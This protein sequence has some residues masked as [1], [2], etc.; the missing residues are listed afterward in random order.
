MH[1]EDLR[2]KELNRDIPTHPPAVAPGDEDKIVNDG[3]AVRS[4]DYNDPP[5]PGGKGKSTG[6][7]VDPQVGG[8][9][10]QPPDASGDAAGRRDSQTRAD[11]L[12]EPRK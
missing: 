9:L 1:D 6:T 10:G 4:R 2:R 8:A 5:P 7:P 11:D 12:H 3:G